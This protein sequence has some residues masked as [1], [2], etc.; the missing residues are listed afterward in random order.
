[1]APIPEEKYR[2]N[3][4]GPLNDR[5]I[6]EDDQSMYSNNNSLMDR[7]Q[8]ELFNHMLAQNFIR[9]A[10][11]GEQNKTQDG[12]EL[13]NSMSELFNNPNTRDK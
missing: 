13:G 7:S 11:R 5:S 3:G 2:D 12:H 1:M 4:R 8:S 9:S 10:D 6:D